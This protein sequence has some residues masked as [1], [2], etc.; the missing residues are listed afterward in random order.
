MDKPHGNFITRTFSRRKASSIRS[1]ENAYLNSPKQKLINQTKLTH[2]FP[3]LNP[4]S[5]HPHGLIF[6]D[7]NPNEHRKITLPEFNID[8][9][10]SPLTSEE[11]TKKLI[12]EINKMII[13]NHKIN[14]RSIFTNEDTYQVPAQNIQ[15][16]IDLNKENILESI[17]YSRNV[18]LPLIDLH[19]G[20]PPNKLHYRH[21]NNNHGKPFT[22]R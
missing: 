2:D 16:I 5:N 15:N 22:F 14:L 13:I 20:G 9:M 19:R 1:S 6:D 21:Q 11:R 17:S 8:D 4:N 3:Y 18:E 10:I 7:L 12:L